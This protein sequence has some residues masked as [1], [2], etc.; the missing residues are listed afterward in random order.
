M[1][2][3]RKIRASRLNGAK[4]R[5][6]VTPEGKRKSSANSARHHLLSKTILLENER[7]DAFADLLVGLTRE[8]NPQTET[9]RALVE[10]MAVSRWRQTRIWAVERAT[11]QSAMEAHDPD[12]TEPAT[13]VALAFRSLADDSRTL[14]LFS[15]YE[16]RFDRQFA[17][18]LN[19]LIKLDPLRRTGLPASSIAEGA[20]PLCAQSPAPQE[21]FCQT[22]PGGAGNDSPSDASANVER[23]AVSSPHHDFCQTNLIPIPD[24]IKDSHETGGHPPAQPDITA[25]GR[26]STLPLVGAGA[27]AA[28]PQTA[29]QPTARLRIPRPSPEQSGIVFMNLSHT[30]ASIRPDPSSPGAAVALVI[31]AHSRADDPE[32]SRNAPYI[33]G[34]RHRSGGQAARRFSQ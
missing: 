5:G 10:T 9:Q 1:S 14:D 27:A 32:V 34:G 16:A 12:T 2:S 17:R 30:T 11:L 22:N 21:D 6:A 29:A 3:E 20:P 19:L 33:E 13:R 7:P 28:V 4:S 26:S 18:S 31:E 25:I 24:T 23:D 8:F 15:R